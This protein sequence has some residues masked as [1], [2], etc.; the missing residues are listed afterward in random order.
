MSELA[1]SAPFLIAMG[2]LIICSGFFS[3]SEAAFFSLR[4]KDRKQ[5]ASGKRSQKLVLELLSN[6]DRLL[7]AI[8]FWNLVINVAYFA[9]SSIVAI[10]FSDNQTFAALFAVISL[11]AII[12][13]SEMLPK[14]FAVLTPVSF[15]SCFA[16]P[17]YYLVR[18]ID[19][20]MLVL[21]RINLYSQRLLWPSLVKEEYLE[22]SDLEKA[23]EL[24]NQDHHIVEQESAILRNIVQLS[25]IRADEWMRPRSQFRYFRPPVGIE[26]IQ[27]E[28]PPSGYLLITE[29]DSEEIEKAIRLRDSYELPGKE[30][31]S[32]AKSVA[33]APWS[34]TVAHIYELM[35][36]RDTEVVAIVNEYGE[37][38]GI[39]TF[40]DVLD[41]VFNYEPSRAKRLLDQNPIHTIIPGKKWLI[42]GMTALRRL[43][44]FI[45][46]E[47][48]ESQSVTVSGII[49]EANHRIAE[50]ND[51][52][53]WGP[54]RFKVLEMPHRGHMLIEMTR[55]D[56]GGES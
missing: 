38:I 47:L 28:L 8:L 55:N 35:R 5:L 18:F 33:Y 32:L 45:G 9:I 15:S 25:N 26:D 21:N 14:T 3:A 16:L 51:Q 1:E 11:F 56:E 20:L 37:T 12:F 46:E 50:V 48:P 27:G 41:T 4:A 42:S 39:L 24:S 10:N 52:C 49:Q 53:D 43:E 44:Q 23:I 29:K 13:L 40:E 36:R 54:L 22:V 7:S 6:P 2:I 30:L 17:L 19:P 34:T 31:E